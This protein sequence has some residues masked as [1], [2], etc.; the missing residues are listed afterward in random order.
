MG[1]SRPRHV[2]R[3]AGWGQQPVP[4]KAPLLQSPGTQAGKL[5][6]LSKKSLWGRSLPPSGPVSPPVIPGSGLDGI[7]WSGRSSPLEF[8][9]LRRLPEGPS[10]MA[11]RRRPASPAHRVLGQCPQVPV[12]SGSCSSGLRAPGGSPSESS[13]F[14]TWDIQRVSPQCVSC[15]EKPRRVRRVQETE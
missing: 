15:Q 12:P 7:R 4:T 2:G 14:H 3:P 8:T 10:Q 1:F 11:G 9:I 5:K 6:V 13:T